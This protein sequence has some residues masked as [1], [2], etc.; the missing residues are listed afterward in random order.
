MTMAHAEG[1]I[2]IEKPANVVFD[3]L[4]EGTNNLL[5]RPSVTDVARV[6]GK[7]SE[8]GAVFKQGLKGPGGRRIDGDY[9][10]VESQPSTLIKFQVI[11]GQAR[12][13]GTYR[14]EGQGNTTRLTFTLEYRSSG[15]VR[16]M[17]GEITK[18][19][20]SEVGLLSNL[21]RYLESS[22]GESS[23]L[24]MLTPR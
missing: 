10:I 21:K 19:M 23:E 22:G 7:P 8:V 13:V 4:M 16:L 20:E 9:Q 18:S 15:L 6:P 11:A 5:W 24:S 2:T 1:S 14:L 3:F 17:D 12:P